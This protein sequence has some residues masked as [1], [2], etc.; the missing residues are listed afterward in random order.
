MAADN[1]PKLGIILPPTR[2]GLGM[3]KSFPLDV[4]HLLAWLRE[5]QSLCVELIDYRIH[6]IN[7]DNYWGDRGVD[8]GVY[9]NFPLCVDYLLR[10]EDPTVKWNSLRIIKDIR[11]AR[12][13]YIFFSVSVLEQFSLEY[14]MA[15][16][17]LAKEI[18]LLFP[19][20]RIVIFGSCPKKH[21][22]CILQ[23]FDFIDAFLE[24]GCEL[25]VGPY[26][27]GAAAGEPLNGFSY[28]QNGKIIY[29]PGKRTDVPFNEFPVPDFSLF[30][31][32]DYMCG[33]A[34]VLPYEI[35]R[36]CSE[37]CFYCY[38]THKNSLSYKTVERVVGDL[39]KL[40]GEYGTN[41]FHFVDGAMNSDLEYLRELCDAM[42]AELPQIRW[43]A[44]ARPVMSYEDI[45]AMKDAGCVHIRWGVEYGSERMLN[46]IKKGTS[47]K[48]IKKTLQDAHGLGIYNYIT[49]LTNTEV[50]NDGDIEETK[51]FIREVRP[52]IDSAH[53]CVFRELGSFDL[54][55][56]VR[57]LEPA[58][59]P[60]DDKKPKY[61]SLFKELGIS[62]VDIIEA[63]AQRLDKAPAGRI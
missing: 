55:K 21:I 29:A 13:D 15:A 56:L 50:E 7:R 2:R 47:L 46:K 49:L 26:V 54:A 44:M 58:A 8:A 10:R 63:V 60:A 32:E 34:L 35:I 48:T 4:S 30:K 37:N 45:R 20:I 6:S 53:E 59:P 41:A 12:F 9:S 16:L 61:Q 14:L 40:S 57:L 24:D 25:S 62:R 38:F 19:R 17:C 18:R 5:K 23:N 27:A 11:P 42:K 3:I 43:S 28:R 22:K 31:K 52:F 36:G 39:K 1:Y 33:G 51:R